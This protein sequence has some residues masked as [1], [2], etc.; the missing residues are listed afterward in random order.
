MYWLK[1]ANY[2]IFA[3]TPTATFTIQSN[4]GES[5]CIV[6]Q[7]LASRFYAG[8]ELHRCTEFSGARKT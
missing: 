4:I 1:D 5:E 8:V 3:R 7:P 6:L 2:A